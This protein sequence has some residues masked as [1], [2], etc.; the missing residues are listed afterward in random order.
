[1]MKMQTRGW[2]KKNMTQRDRRNDAQITWFF[3]F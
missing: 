3:F 1:M 2:Q